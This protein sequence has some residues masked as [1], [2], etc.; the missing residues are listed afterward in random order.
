M[1][2]SFALGVLRCTGC[3]E[4]KDC[5][6]RKY[7]GTDCNAPGTRVIVR[8]SNGYYYGG[9]VLSFDGPDKGGWG[10]PNNGNIRVK[11]TR[12]NPTHHVSRA[13]VYACKDAPY[14]Y[15]SSSLPASCRTSCAVSGIQC[16]LE[17]PSSPGTEPAAC[18]DGTHKEGNRGVCSHEERDFSRFGPRKWFCREKGVVGAW[19]GKDEH[20]KIK[21]SAC[22]HWR[23]QKPKPDYH[24]CNRNA[25]C[26]SGHC[27]LWWGLQKKCRPKEGWKD[28]SNCVNHHHCKS[29]KCVHSFGTDRLCMPKIGWKEGDKCTNDAHCRTTSHHAGSCRENGKVDGDCCALKSNSL[30]K[31]GSCNGWYSPKWL[32]LCAGNK[33]YKYECRGHMYCGGQP[34]GTC[35]R[36]LAD[37]Q[38][39][40]YNANCQSGHCRHYWGT[41][42]KCEPYGGWPGEKKLPNFH[43]CSYNLECKSGWCKHYWGAWHKCYVPGLWK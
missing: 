36:K 27:D 4:D 42:H 25:Q 1:C 19:C 7:I 13:D 16:P 38:D 11:T 37:M 12:W 35:Q 9:D 20:C 22:D 31:G 41:Q 33:Y 29:R 10:A 3:A 40:T 43:D 15:H 30:T 28:Y 23:C 6:E 21:G 18:W 32:G 26:N 2:K 5:S 8:R 24:G 14:N 17:Q 34:F 39:C